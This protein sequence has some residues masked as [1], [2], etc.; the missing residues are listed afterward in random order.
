MRRGRCN[1]ATGTRGSVVVEVQ[2]T[3]VFLLDLRVDALV[4]QGLDGGIEHAL[5]LFVVLAHTNGDFRRHQRVADA[6]TVLEVR[7]LWRGQET[8]LRLQLVL[9]RRIETAKYQ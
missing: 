5:E 8:H 4:V 2:V 7:P 9:D 3:E 6:F 1:T